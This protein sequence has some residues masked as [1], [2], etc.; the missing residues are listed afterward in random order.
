V[1]HFG[2][3]HGEDTHP[4]TVGGVL[5]QAQDDYDDDVEDAENGVALN[6]LQA[7]QKAG[8][9]QANGHGHGQG[10]EEVSGGDDEPGSANPPAYGDSDNLF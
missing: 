9:K 4:A 7:G 10:F 1:H 8:Q 6:P 2:S 3:A 5:A